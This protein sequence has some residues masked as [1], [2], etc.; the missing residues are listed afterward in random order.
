MKRGEP[1]V[2]LHCLHEIKP[3]L[4]RVTKAV[5]DNGKP[6]RECTICFSFVEAD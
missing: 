5:D 1:L 2:K 6:M 3:E 4:L